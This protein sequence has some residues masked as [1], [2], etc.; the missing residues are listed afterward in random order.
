MH[1]TLKALYHRSIP[2]EIRYPIGRLRRAGLDT[3]RRLSSSG[4]LPPRDLLQFVQMTPWV[5]EYLRVGKLSHGAVCRVFE[6][7]G[8]DT[9]REVR[10]LDFGCGLGRTLRFF[11]DDPRRL[12]GCDIDSRLVDWTRRAF[13]TMDIRLS[14][15]APPLPWEASHFDGLFAISVFTHFDVDQQRAW[16]EEAYRLLAPGGLVAMT[17]MGPHA[18]GGFPNLA[19]DANRRELLENGFFFHRGGSA[20]NANGAFHTA[21][22]IRR[23]FGPLFELESWTEGGLDGFQDLS[24]LRRRSEP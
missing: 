3:L 5:D 24:V 16:A 13:P 9:T 20:F 22:G 12:C 4:P 1:Q 6:E 2:P 15:T 17:T 23:F 21:E 18:L 11:R 8:L 10:I 19:N 7:H 14:S